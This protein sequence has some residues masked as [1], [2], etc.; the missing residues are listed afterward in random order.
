MVQIIRTFI[1]FIIS[2]ILISCAS[3]R[4]LNN[5]KTIA[6]VVQLSDNENC[7]LLIQINDKNF[8]PI[9]KN[10]TDLEVG[11]LI[12]VDY[13]VVQE[14]QTTCKQS[15]GT[16]DINC[17]KVIK[18]SCPKFLSINDLYWL[19]DL[20]SKMRPQKIIYFQNDMDED[21]F[22]LD[23]GK[24][25]YLYNCKGILDCTAATDDLKSDCYLKYSALKNGA[26]LYQQ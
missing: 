20:K 23:M 25:K 3:K 26:T 10:K 14:D 19:N 8:K 9:F 11:S 21:I 24:Y 2:F 17:F 12:S 7:G 22:V 6:K 5:C 4:N 18:T 13:K 15:D 1:F 16:I